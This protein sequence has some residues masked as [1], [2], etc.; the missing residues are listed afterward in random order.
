[1]RVGAHSD[2]ISCLSAQVGA[3]N[4]HSDP[5]SRLSAQVGLE[6]AHSDPISRLSAQHKPKKEEKTMN[7]TLILVGSSSY[8]V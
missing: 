6:N 3:G 4:A 7:P 2:S 8:L 1:M 5:I